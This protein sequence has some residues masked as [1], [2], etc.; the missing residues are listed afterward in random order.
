MAHTGLET[1]PHAQAL[2]QALALPWLGE[3]DDT[4]ATKP[5]PPY[6][7]LLVLTPKGLELRHLGQTRQHPLYID[8]VGGRFGHRRRG[9]GRQSL[10]R[11]VG[12]KGGIKPRV[13]DATPG[14]GR[15]A[16]L[17]AA[18]GCRVEMV[19]RSPIIAALL[20]DGLKRAREAP[21]TQKIARDHLHLVVGDARAYLTNTP[22]T[23]RPDVVYLDPMYPHRDKSALVKKEMRW[24]RELVGNDSDAPQLLAVALESAKKRVVVKR[25]RLAPPL[26]GPAPGFIIPGRTTRF[27]VYPIANTAEPAL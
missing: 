5:A 26:E 19:E 4:E 14:L 13:V 2:A 9:G 10:A 3:M 11:A 27:D 20:A 22:T 12:F 23:Q 15:D 16:F 8:F 18:L 17:L 24:L 6:T 1:Q 21:E 25:P 7:H